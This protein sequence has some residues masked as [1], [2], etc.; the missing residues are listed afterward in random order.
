M[1]DKPEY[2]ALYDKKGAPTDHTNLWTVANI[3]E[4]PL[5]D[6]LRALPDGRVVSLY[7]YCSPAQ[8]QQLIAT[9]YGPRRLIELG[10]EI[11]V[12]PC[13][14]GAPVNF[15]CSEIFYTPPSK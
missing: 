15:N 4:Y 9:T 1:L 11:D 5:A 8:A 12:Q 13:K 6:H 2:T 7:A 3:V 10:W 14:E